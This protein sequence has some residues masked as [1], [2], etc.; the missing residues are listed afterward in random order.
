MANIKLKLNSNEKIEALLQETYE[1]ACMAINQ[2]QEEI[3]KLSNA[4]KLS[5]IPAMDERA[6]YGKAIHDY[7][8]DKEKAMRLKLDIAKFMGAVLM[9]N[10]NLN[11]AIAE[12]EQS[13]EP[14]SLGL[15]AIKKLAEED[16][17]INQPIT[18]KRK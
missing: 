11:K 13:K 8:T 2:T 14:T 4:T 17:N 18:Y 10:G 7:L 1:Q 3:N 5:E 9:N 16:S 6:K 15:S 12:E